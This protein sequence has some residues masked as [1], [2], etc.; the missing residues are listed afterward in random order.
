MAVAAGEG[1]L[2]VYSLK[3]IEHIRAEIESDGQL[4]RS[5]F[6]PIQEVSTV[7]E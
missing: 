4:L 3:T 7:G 2:V 6:S 1:T 5:K